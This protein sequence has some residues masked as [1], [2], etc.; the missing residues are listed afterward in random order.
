MLEEKDLVMLQTYAW[1]AS[2]P[3]TVSEE[4]ALDWELGVWAPP[5]FS[6]APSAS[7]VLHAS[8]GL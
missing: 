7:L 8:P 2:V 3:L 6:S 5:W 4:N 1:G